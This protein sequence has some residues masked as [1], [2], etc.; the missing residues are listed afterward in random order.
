ME[1]LVQYDTRGRH[2]S[3]VLTLYL[4][5]RDADPNPDSHPGEKSDPD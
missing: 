3:K 4:E 1:V 5:P 2:L